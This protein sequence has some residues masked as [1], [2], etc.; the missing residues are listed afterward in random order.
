MGDL[1]IEVHK[2]YH[3]VS[4][5]EKVLNNSNADT[6]FFN[7]EIFSKTNKNGENYCINLSNTKV[8]DVGGLGILMKCLN[9]ARKKKMNITFAGV[10]DYIVK[11]TLLRKEYEKVSVL[12][13]NIYHLP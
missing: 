8:E 3:I 1:E 4:M 12:V 6:L 7:F 2:N 9:L 11:E 5:E 10:T 13:K